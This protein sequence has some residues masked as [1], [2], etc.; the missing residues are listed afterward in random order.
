MPSQEPQTGEGVI[1]CRDGEEA[2][3]VAKLCEAKPDRRRHLRKYAEGELGPDR[4]FYFRGPESKLNLRAHNLQ[5]FSAIAEG[6]DDET[7]LFHLQ[8]GDYSTWFRQAIKDEALADEIQAVEKGQAQDA[9][10]TRSMIKEAI[11]KKYTAAA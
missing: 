8:N 1:W 10:T 3:F 11:E 9:Q 4:S 5:M 2:P 6:V 7:W